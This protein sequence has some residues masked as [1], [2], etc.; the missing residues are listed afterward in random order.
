MALTAYPS[1]RACSPLPIT[2]GALI[3]M[4]L[5]RIEFTWF[6]YGTT[7]TYFLLHLSSPFGGRVLPAILHCGVR[8]FLHALDQIQGTA[9][10]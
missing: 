3:Y 4:A 7:R 9:I 5:H 2:I 1:A 10:R 8:T 6:H